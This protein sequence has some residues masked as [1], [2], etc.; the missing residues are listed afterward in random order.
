M[1]TYPD[2]SPRGDMKEQT[3]SAARAV[4]TTPMHVDLHQIRPAYMADVSPSQSSWTSLK[5][6][7]SSR[8]VSGT[9]DATGP[10]EYASHNGH[11]REA[12]VMEETG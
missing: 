4:L 10:S 12:P 6:P 3:P 2:D 11:D 8:N 9:T 7:A 5:L 1:R